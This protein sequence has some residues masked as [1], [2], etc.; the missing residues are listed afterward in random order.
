VTI[1]TLEAAIRDGIG[2][3]IVPRV[4]DHLKNRHKKRKYTTCACRYCALKRAA[5]ALIGQRAAPG[6]YVQCTRDILRAEWCARLNAEI[7]RIF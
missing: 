4:L 2:V 3:E 1:E 7:E 5:T 6:Y